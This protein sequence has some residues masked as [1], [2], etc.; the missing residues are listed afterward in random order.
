MW[1]LTLV[2]GSIRQ[3]RCPNQQC[4]LREQKRTALLQLSEPNSPLALD[5]DAALPGKVHETDPESGVSLYNIA[6]KAGHF[7]C[8]KCDPGACPSC[9]TMC[10]IQSCIGEFYTQ[11]CWCRKDS[12]V[13]LKT[14]LWWFRKYD[15]RFMTHDTVKRTFCDAD[16]TGG[17]CD[18]DRLQCQKREEACK[19]WWWC[20]LDPPKDP[21][22]DDG[23]PTGFEYTESMTFL[24]R[25]RRADMSDLN[26][27]LAEAKAQKRVEVE[28]ND[29]GLF[30]FAPGS[31]ECG[32]ASLP[33][34][35]QDATTYAWA[36]RGYM[37]FD[38]KSCKG[39][40]FDQKCYCWDEVLQLK[41]ED[42][43]TSEL[44]CDSNCELGVCAGNTCSSQPP[45]PPSQPPPPPQLDAVQVEGLRSSE[46][47]KSQNKMDPLVTS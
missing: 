18:T 22:P 10:D 27:A 17:I 44:M 33:P 46:L 39:G 36:D 2:L 47:K 35:V 15:A 29:I 23:W 28:A 38:T 13:K 25:E 24:Q 4:H 41:G 43:K 12:Q 11:E 21:I 19:P 16:C 8:S 30:S 7:T 14:P 9:N 5:T 26:R 6:F 37:V 42:P 31:W 34:K 20:N 40:A 3:G 1:L 45:P 32:L